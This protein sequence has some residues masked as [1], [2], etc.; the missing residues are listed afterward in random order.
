MTRKNRVLHSIN[1]DNAD[2]CV[3]VFVRQDGT[4][5][6]EEFRR[7]AEDARGWFVIGSH[8]IRI[9]NDDGAALVA[10][11]RAVSWLVPHI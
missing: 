9:F 3:D 5:G 1:N 2:R 11:K 6:F 4:Y 8:S 7:D 10:A